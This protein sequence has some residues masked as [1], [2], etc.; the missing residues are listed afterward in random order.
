L[1]EISDN[2]LFQGFVRDH[3][4]RIAEDMREPDLR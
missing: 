1:L 3:L 4:R 2:D